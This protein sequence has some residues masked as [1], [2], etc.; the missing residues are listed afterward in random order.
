MV[1]RIGNDAVVLLAAGV[2]LE[3]VQR[4]YLRQFCGFVVYASEI[5]HG[6]HGGY[7]VMTADLFGGHDLFKGM[8]DFGHQPAG[9]TIIA[10][11]KCVLLEEALSA[12]AA[13]AALSKMQEGIS[14]QRNILDRLHPIVV[15]I[16]CG[17]AAGRANMLFRGSSMLMWSSS[18]IFSTFVIIMSS[19]FRSFAV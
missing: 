7:V 15:H 8:D 18:Q 6:S 14:C 4:E 11:Q 19:K 1:S 3:L 17:R 12:S 16:V 5:A 9:D 13:V 10:R 2:S